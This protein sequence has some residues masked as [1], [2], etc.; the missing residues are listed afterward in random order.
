MGERGRKRKRARQERYSRYG[1]ES[2]RERERVVEIT[3]KE[4]KRVGGRRR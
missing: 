4:D 3:L 2:K 1:T